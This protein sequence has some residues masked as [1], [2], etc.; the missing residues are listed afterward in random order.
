M[1]YSHG[2]SVKNSIRFFWVFLVSILVVD[3]EGANGA[4]HELRT[5]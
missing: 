3:F 5:T 2:D 1:Q 4:F